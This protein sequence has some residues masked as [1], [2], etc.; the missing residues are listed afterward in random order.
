MNISA[1]V[2]KQTLVLSIIIFPNTG[3]YVIFAYILITCLMPKMILL[4][5]LEIWNWRRKIQKIQREC[6]IEI[7]G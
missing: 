5:Y 6:S 7:L 3:V 2:F 1:V 4:G